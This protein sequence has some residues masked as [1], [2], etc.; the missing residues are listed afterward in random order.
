MVLAPQKCR[1]VVVTLDPISQ[2]FEQGAILLAYRTAGALLC[3]GIQRMRPNRNLQLVRGKQPFIAN[4]REFACSRWERVAQQAQ[5]G[6]PVWHCQRIAGNPLCLA[7]IERLIDQ[8]GLAERAAGL[9]LI[10]TLGEK[11]DRCSPAALPCPPKAAQ[12]ICR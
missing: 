11:H 9:D 1:V 8:D 12:L 6:M 5:S 7:D 4:A 3:L 10:A 2:R